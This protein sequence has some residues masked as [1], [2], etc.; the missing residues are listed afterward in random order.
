VHAGTGQCIFHAPADKKDPQEFRNALAAQIRQWRQ[1]PKASVWDFSG[2]VFVDVDR[3]PGIPWSLW[4]RKF[5][6]FRCA[7]F[8]VRTNFLS[9]EFALAASFA[10]SKFNGD[11]DFVL[12]HFTSY[13]D[14]GSAHL[15]RGAEFSYAL[16]D[17]H[18][19]FP[20]V[21]V[22]GNV[23]FQFARFAGDAN[24]T[25]ALFTGTASFRSSQFRGE[26]SFCL[27]RFIQNAYFKSAVFY[28]VVD[29]EQASFGILADFSQSRIVG[30]VCLCWPGEGKARVE[31]TK[32]EEEKSLT[33]SAEIQRGKLRLRNLQFDNTG[34]LDLRRN[35]LAPDCELVIEDC[36]MHRVL[37]EGTDCTKIRFYNCEW[38][39]ALGRQM[40]GDEW[41]ARPY[42]KR[43]F[44]KRARLVLRICRGKRLGLL[45]KLAKPHAD[46][47][48]VALTYQQLA[49]RFHE[50]FNHSVA[51]DFDRGVFEMKRLMNRRFLSRWFGL[52]AWYR[53]LSNYG[54]SVLRPVIVLAASIFAFALG[55]AGTT[56]PNIH[57]NCYW[58]F[59]DYLG[60]SLQVSYLNR[61]GLEFARG[62]SIGVNVFMALQ[63]VLT[64]TLVALFVFAIRRRF[65]HG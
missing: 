52:A 43:S 50:D 25:F 38:P 33:A 21:Q 19:S 20:S 37:L 13:A 32:G 30:H 22:A 11:A 58:S 17:E 34:V 51:N 45:R 56:R 18:A 23:S 5:N 24:F 31:A 47:C 61:A 49:R 2:W 1:P 4:W 27:A 3:K 9:A 40:V 59:W 10:L 15:A 54:G 6:L 35:S 7:V 65:R 46:W 28:S 62:N 64:A 8:P 44:L 36:K 63:V 12:A 39:V 26:T 53:Y 14:F 41:R 16:F 48:L 55:Y 57:E 60:L 29:L 42:L